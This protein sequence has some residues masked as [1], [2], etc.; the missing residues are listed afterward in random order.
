MSSVTSV[1]SFLAS[2][3]AI[4]LFSTSAHG[5]HVEPDDI[6]KTIKSDCGDI[7]D[8]VDI[9]KQPSLKNGLLGDYKIQ[10][11]PTREPPKIHHKLLVT[12]ESFHQQTWRKSGSCP[13]G[14]VPVRRQP[15]G[16][17]AEVANRTRP[18]FTY[19]RPAT[20]IT[21]KK[22]QED[23]TRPFFSYGF[24]AL[25][26]TDQ[27][28]QVDDRQEVAAA[29]GVNGPYHG[30][31]ASI[32]NWKVNVD[33]NEF[34]MSY[35]LLASPHERKFTPIKGT[36][37]PDTK[38]Q[39]A[40]GLAIY[41]SV[42]GDNNPRLFIYA[43]N[44]GGVK[45]NCLN[46]ECGFIQTS[47]EI[48]LGAAIG[49]G[50]TVGG[51]LLFVHFALYRDTGPGVW[52]LSINEVPL[53]YFKPEMFPVPF[54]ESFHNEMGGRVLNTRPGG[55]HTLTAMGSGMFPSAGLNNAASIAF[56]MAINNNGGDQVDDPVNTIVTK[57]K[58]Y[59]VKDFGPDKNNPGYD[60]A[61]GGP[62]GYFCDQ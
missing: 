22:F 60:I 40:A 23:K 3:A 56:Y 1:P 14:T 52:W 27:K 8:C 51:E 32:P 37:P 19:G 50:S 12:N 48:A 42:L 10:L 21:D 47:N 7:I 16:F 15:T 28:F 20:T 35:L 58:C 11:K 31:R 45:S 39:M 25:V 49:G 41:P 13:E 61:F 46:L 29:Y 4:L 62:G 43:T 18:F 30:A 2:L 38:N 44:D 5:V 53:G 17:N 54:I 26:V 33:P 9:Y 24:P 57:P 36:D 34:S 6:V 59:D 55:K